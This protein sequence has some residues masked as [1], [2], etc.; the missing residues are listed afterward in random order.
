VEIAIV[1]LSAVLA[2]IGAW[3]SFRLQR[4]RREELAAPRVVRDLYGLRTTG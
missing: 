2:G 4:R 3:W 1:L